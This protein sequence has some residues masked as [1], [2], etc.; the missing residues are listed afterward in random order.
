MDNFS[1][2]KFG[3]PLDE[4]L[5]TIDIK[6]K[7]FSSC[8]NDLV[9]DFTY[10]EGWTFN[11]GNSCTFKAHSKCV[12]KTGSGCT[13]KTGHSCTFNTDW[14]C[15]FQTRSYCT[16]NTYSDCTFNTGWSCIFYT[17]HCC[18]LSLYDINSHEFKTHD[19][20][21]IIIDR[22]DKK[23]YVLTEEFVQLQKVKN[24]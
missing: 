19:G 23:H 12:F 10:L 3:N 4:S 7:V 13:F 2:T 22:K 14:S 24:G 5:Y 20:N 18:T 16:F 11:T 17:G 1:I 6:N 9:L 21:S 8:E 15:I